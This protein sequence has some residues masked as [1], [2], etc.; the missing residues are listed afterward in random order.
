MFNVIWSIRSDYP[1]SSA[2][3]I[4]SRCAY[5]CIRPTTDE[6]SGD[7][8]T[9]SEFGLVS[10][11]KLKRHKNNPTGFLSL[12]PWSRLIMGKV[13]TG[14]A[15]RFAIKWT[16]SACKRGKRWALYCDSV[17]YRQMPSQTDSCHVHCLSYV[18]RCH[19]R[20]DVNL[21][22]RSSKVL[23]TRIGF[24]YPMFTLI[25]HDV[26]M[27]H[28]EAYLSWCSVCLVTIHDL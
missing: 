8:L 19:L 10:G 18:V 24:I 23:E 6:Q 14:T 28:A 7:R 3:L 20:F 22:L 13:L 26:P 9:S 27:C 5:T 21:S 12:D 4:T 16:R 15:V 1:M 25:R 2:D 17:C 11:R